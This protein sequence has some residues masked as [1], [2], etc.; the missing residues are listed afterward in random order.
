MNRRSF[1]IALPAV[2]ALPIAIV[3]GPV[4]ET[5]VWIDAGTVIDANYLRQIYD[6]VDEVL[7]RHRGWVLRGSSEV[8]RV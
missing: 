6:N 8:D 2:A 4:V 1:L 7:Q 3:N 5:R